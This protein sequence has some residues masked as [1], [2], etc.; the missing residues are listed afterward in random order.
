MDAQS[1]KIKRPGEAVR[2]PLSVTK[3]GRQWDLYSVRYETPDGEFGTYIYAISF[4]HAAAIVEDLKG[5]AT[6]DGRVCGLA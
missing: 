3:D 1:D 6:L 4:E 5:S 2:L